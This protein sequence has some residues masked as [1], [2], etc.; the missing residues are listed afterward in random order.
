MRPVSLRCRGDVFPFELQQFGEIHND[1][2]QGVGRG[3]Q[4]VRGKGKKRA[5]RQTGA[6]RWL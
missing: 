4:E 1:T 5:K 6:L 2:V 3:D